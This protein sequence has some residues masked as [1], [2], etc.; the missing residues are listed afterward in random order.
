ML[1]C[2]YSESKMS[3]RADYKVSTVESV[4]LEP[5]GGSKSTPEHKTNGINKFGK[6]IQ[7]DFFLLYCISEV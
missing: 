6:Y 7:S 5:L 2:S 4:E 3:R 1:C